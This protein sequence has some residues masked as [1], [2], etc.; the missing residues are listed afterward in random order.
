M[1]SYRNV[2]SAKQ[3]NEDFPN[4]S[5]GTQ[6]AMDATDAILHRDHAMSGFSDMGRMQIQNMP[7]YTGIAGEYEEE[8]VFRNDG[9]GVEN[10]VDD[11]TYF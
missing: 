5:S 6:V 1:H 8:T 10:G 4:V 11:D 3:V 2:C 9:R 7:D